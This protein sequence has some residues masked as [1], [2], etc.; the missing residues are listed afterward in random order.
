MPGF[1]RQ[2]KI[3]TKSAMTHYSNL[4]QSSRIPN[5]MH[6]QYLHPFSVGYS[7]SYL[8][9]A[10]EIRGVAMCRPQTDH[11]PNQSNGERIFIKPNFLIKF[12]LFL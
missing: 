9:F 10:G 6:L 2:R 4:R 3:H 11:K 5:Q 12:D 8:K 7:Q 1:K